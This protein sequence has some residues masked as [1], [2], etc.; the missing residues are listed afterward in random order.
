LTIS[1]F[2]DGDIKAGLNIQDDVTI[3]GSILSNLAVFNGNGALNSMT[4][5]LGL[6]LPVFKAG[7]IEIY[8]SCSGFPIRQD[9]ELTGNE[10]SEKILRI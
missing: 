3:S 5:D 7:D 9:M 8:L 6:L 10:N 4:F 1:T 2:S